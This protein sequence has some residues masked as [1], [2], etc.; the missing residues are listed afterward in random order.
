[1]LNLSHKKLDVYKIA[2]KLVEEVY[3]STNSFPPEERYILTS[4]LRRAAVS[5]CSNIA[6]GSARKSKQ[7]KK[8]FFEISRSS[9]VEIDTQIEISLVIKYLQ[10]E[11]IKE[12]ESYL[13]RTFM[14]LCKLINKLENEIQN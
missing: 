7:E 2:M 11:M 4:Q 8:R 9:V 5:V 6:E 10:N 14:M 3:K 13:E 1:M 12:L